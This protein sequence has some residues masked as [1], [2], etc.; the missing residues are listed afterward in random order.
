MHSTIDASEI[1]SR[2]QWIVS[3]LALAIFFANACCLS[4]AAAQQVA[5]SSKHACCKKQ[6]DEKRVPAKS[7]DC[8]RRIVASVDSTPT[9]SHAPLLPVWNVLASC[10]ASFID[11][12]RSFSSF[13]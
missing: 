13:H 8:C 11:F 4:H 9:H 7:C 10:D 5:A 6:H 2:S 1:M 3:L 12:S